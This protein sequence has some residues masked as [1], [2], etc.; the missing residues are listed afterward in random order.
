VVDVFQ[1]FTEMGKIGKMF[2]K[3]F[4]TFLIVLLIFIIDISTKTYALNNLLP[5]NPEAVTSFLN[6]TL[7]FNHGAAFSLLSEAGGWQ[8][9]F[10]IA[11]SIVVIIIIIY[12]LKKENFSEYVPFSFVL[13]G[14]IGNL[15]DRIYYGYV[16]DFIEFYYKDLYWPIFNVAD[17]AISV[18]IILLL[19]NMFS[20]DIKK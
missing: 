8:R 2:N 5:Y 12:I 3:S 6:F 4:F 1:M 14:A 15:Y 17:I 19:Y 11:F 20:K 16:I 13:A 7:A 10:F 18:G 9:W